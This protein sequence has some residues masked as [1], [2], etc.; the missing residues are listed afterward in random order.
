MKTAATRLFAIFGSTLA[1]T[2]SA[3]AL[4][5]DKPI[6][7]KFSHVVADS[8]PKGQGAMKFKEVAEE[9][10]PGRVEVQVF[11]NSQLFGDARE[12]EALL[13]GDV[14]ILAPSLSK[15]DRYTPKLQI[16]DLPF[17]FDDMDAVDRFHAS[18]AVRGLRVS[19]QDG[20]IQ[21]LAYWHNGM[22]QLSTN[23]DK[24]A[25]PDDIEGLIVR[26]H[27]SDVLEDQLRALDAS[28]QKLAFSG[29]YPARQTG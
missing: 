27:A 1:M 9:L 29:V 25:V 26:V 7:V 19:M 11:P 20:R 10:L 3:S 8:T 5:Q 18:E 22:K 21:G 12:L 2:F 15:F 24:V 4:A 6:V 17:L 13:L 28:P 23:K 14:Q 16:F